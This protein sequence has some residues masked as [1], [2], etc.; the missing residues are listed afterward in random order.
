MT[1]SPSRFLRLWGGGL[2]FMPTPQK[3]LEPLLL[4]LFVCLPTQLKITVLDSQL[5]LRG[6]DMETDDDMMTPEDQAYWDG[7]PEE[8]PGV[9]SPADNL[10]QALLEARVNIIM[11]IKDRRFDEDFEDGI[12]AGQ[13]DATVRSLT[14]AVEHLELSPR[15]RYVVTHVLK[16]GTQPEY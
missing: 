11:E 4:L 12:L 5:M 7:M 15:Q 9:P 13:L 2:I 8:T 6:K 14:L 1:T 16:R 10:A 3:E